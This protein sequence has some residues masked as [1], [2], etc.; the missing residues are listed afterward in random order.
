LGDSFGTFTFGQTELRGLFL[1]FNLNFFVGAT[2][3]GLPWDFFL[4]NSGLGTFEGLI[5]KVFWALFEIFGHILFS[6]GT[7][8]RSIWSKAHFKDTLQG[9]LWSFFKTPLSQ[10]VSERPLKP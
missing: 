5:L 6:L 3:K 10:S 1:D 7:F 8:E 2:S 4:A 9:S